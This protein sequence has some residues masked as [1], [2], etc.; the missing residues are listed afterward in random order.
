MK[1]V[2]I[3]CLV[4]FMFLWGLTL[5]GNFSSGSSNLFE[6]AKQ[7]FEE[8]I[9]KPGSDY[10]NLDLVPSDYAINKTAHKIEDFISSTIRRIFS[11]IE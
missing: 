11:F 9:N 7:E 3:F 1:K 4:G 2:L 5:G 6:E 8:N 10:Q